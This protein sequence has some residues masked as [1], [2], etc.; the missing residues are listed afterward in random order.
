MQQPLVKIC[1]T[2][3][4]EDADSA[5]ELGADYLGVIVDYPA[6]PRHV[7][8]ED[9]RELFTQ[10]AIPTVAVTVNQSLDALLRLAEVLNPAALQ[11]HGDESAETVRVLKER[12]LEVWVACSG[13]TDVAR[14]RALEMLEAGADAILIDARVV[15]A[16]GIVYGGTGLRGDWE[17]A[18]VLG[19]KGI[20]VVLSGGLSPE[21]VGEAIREVRPW[22]VDVVSGVETRKGLKDAEKMRRFI[23]EA[24]SVAL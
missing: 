9:A 13:E 7:S 5:A 15:S 24:R 14:R 4:R 21:N 17:L 10:I 3:N 11:L 12:G 23:E 1:G 8:I 6:S 19:Q 16:Q 20:R 18:R 22:M 2:T